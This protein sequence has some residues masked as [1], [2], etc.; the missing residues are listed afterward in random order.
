MTASAAAEAIGTLALFMSVGPGRLGAIDCAAA[1]DEGGQ[2]ARHIRLRL[3][4]RL[5]LH[6]LR[7]LRFTR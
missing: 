1:G 5:L 6:T 7:K 4:L 2:A 3:L